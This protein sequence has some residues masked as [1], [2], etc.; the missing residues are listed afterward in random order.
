MTLGIAMGNAAPATKAVAQIVLL[1]GKCAN[2]PRILAE[3][4]RVIA[5]VERVANLFVTKNV[6]SLVIIL[7]TALA[8]LAFPFLPRQ[9]TLL[10]TFVIGIPAAILA[11]APD[12][13]RHTPGFL[14]RVLALSV[15]SGADAGAVSFIAHDTSVSFGDMP[16][17]EKSVS[18]LAALLLTF[19]WLLFVLARPCA[20]WK[21]ALIAAMASLVS[22]AFLTDIGN[23]WF[24]IFVTKE[25]LLD[26]LVFGAFG[27]LVVEV[28]YRL[29]RR[30]DRDRD[31]VGLAKTSLEKP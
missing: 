3:G 1:D 12:N 7:A 26:G 25:S 18:A 16:P 29:S 2:M 9:M 23:R 22:L 14:K 17:Q 20:V 30:F 8:G 6:M 27:A 19:V 21:V 11:L 10:S 15:P 4:R 28:A 31:L 24:Q 13:Q 5:N